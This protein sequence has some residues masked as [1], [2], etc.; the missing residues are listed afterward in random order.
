MDTYKLKL[1]LAGACILAALMIIKIIMSNITRR[2]TKVDKRRSEQ[3]NFSNKRTSSQDMSTAELVELI[4]K[5]ARS[6]ILPSMEVS[7]TKFTKLEEKIILSGWKG[8]TPTTYIALDVTLKILAGVMGCLFA[9]ENIWL[10]LI[11]GVLLG[12]GMPYLFN[13]SIKNRTFALLQEFPDFIRITQGFLISGM[14]L[15]EAIENAIPY[16]GPTWK[17]V[18]EEFLVN[19][20]L[21]SQNDCLDMLK[22]TVPIFEVNEFFSL[23]QLNLEQGI[24]V[25]ECFESQADKIKGM[26]MDVIMGKIN[27]RKTMATIVQAPL[28]LC[29]MAGFMLPTISGMLNMGF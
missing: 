17:P 2:D 5:P 25:R 1:I 16:V 15:V 27:G 26:Q 18:L 29:M 3:L 10:G 12:F 24:D 9:A 7:D 19:A 11:W 21:Y 8:F 14:P 28:M 23:L 20:N 4:T 22:T 6:Y 13:N